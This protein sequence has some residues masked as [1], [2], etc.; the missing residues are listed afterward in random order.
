[1]LEQKLGRQESVVWAY[2]TIFGRRPLET[3]IQRGQSYFERATRQVETRQVDDS[4]AIRSH[5]QRQVW[6]GYLRAM[7]ASNEFMFVD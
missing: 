4:P 3:E 6:S 2:R 1:M 7:I 5:N